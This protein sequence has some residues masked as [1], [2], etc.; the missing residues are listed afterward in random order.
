MLN[1]TE[2]GLKV[3]RQQRAKYVAVFR[4][5]KTVDIPSHTVKSFWADTDVK[6]EAHVNNEDWRADKNQSMDEFEALPGMCMLQLG[7]LRD[8]AAANARGG[9]AKTAK[10]DAAAT[11]ATDATD[12]AATTDGKSAE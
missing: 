1:Y 10:T 8:T 11:D 9:K 6:P 12:A 5:R 3:A 4:R 7:G 2:E